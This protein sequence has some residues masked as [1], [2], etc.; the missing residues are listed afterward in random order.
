M[1]FYEGRIWPKDDMITY[2]LILLKTC[3]GGG[4]HFNV[5]SSYKTDKFLRILHG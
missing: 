2:L 1:S 4:M 5:L 3:P